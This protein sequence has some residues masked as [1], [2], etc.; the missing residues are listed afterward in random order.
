[1]VANSVTIVLPLGSLC[2][3]CKPGCKMMSKFKRATKS[4][5]FILFYVCGAVMDW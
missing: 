4:L 1:M 3:Y 2:I 5:D